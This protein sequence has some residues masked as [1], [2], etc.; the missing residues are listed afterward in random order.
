MVDVSCVFGQRFERVIWR[1]AEFFC[2]CMNGGCFLGFSGKGMTG[3]FGHLRRIVSHACWSKASGGACWKIHSSCC[4]QD[5]VVCQ[6][7]DF[8]RLVRLR[9]FRIL[10]AQHASG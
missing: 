1:F 4:K 9:F 10:W 2:L 7:A 6:V 8:P 5:T 3:S